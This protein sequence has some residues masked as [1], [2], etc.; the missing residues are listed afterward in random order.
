MEV[1]TSSQLEDILRGNQKNV[2]VIGVMLLPEYPREYGFTIEQFQNQCVQSLRVCGDSL[3]SGSAVYLILNLSI[4][5]KNFSGLEFLRRY[6][7]QKLGDLNNKVEFDIQFI[8][9]EKD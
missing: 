7:E 4:K 8:V 2:N 9:K 3:K 6:L 5:V 1:K